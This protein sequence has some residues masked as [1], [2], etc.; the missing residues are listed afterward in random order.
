MNDLD[1]S[2]YQGELDD[3]D[4]PVPPASLRWNWLAMVALAS[5]CGLLW[6]EL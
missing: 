2:Q 3:E 1:S 4:D 5:V 6:W